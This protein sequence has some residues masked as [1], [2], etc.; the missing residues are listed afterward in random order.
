MVRPPQTDT[1]QTR[2][3][4][5]WEQGHLRIADTCNIWKLKILT[6]R[7]CFISSIEVVRAVLFALLLY[8]WQINLHSRD[9][10]Q[11]VSSSKQT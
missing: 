11:T 4:V 5:F 10:A 8:P 3:I 1:F 9:Y 2:T 6:K 7:G